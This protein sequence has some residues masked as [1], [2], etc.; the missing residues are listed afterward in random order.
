MALINRKTD[1]ATRVLLHLAMLPLGT[2]TTAQE[3]A[4][5]RL[6]PARLVGQ[7]VSRLSKAG[8]LVTKRGKGGGLQMARPASEINLLQIC[9]AIQGPLVLN[10]CVGPAEPDCRLHRECPLH[11]TWAKAQE[12]LEQ[13][14]RNETLDQLAARGYDLADCRSE[15]TT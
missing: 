8:L 11:E 9:E 1:Y 12:L 5:R 2:W 13:R 7:I 10:E 3:V 14:L 6:I 4:E 15:E